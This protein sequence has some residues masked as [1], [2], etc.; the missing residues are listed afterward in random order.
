MFILG[1]KRLVYLYLTLFSQEERQNFQFSLTLSLLLN[2]GLN[3]LHTTQK[4]V[5]DISWEVF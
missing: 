4:T 1:L 3:V 2:K 5:N